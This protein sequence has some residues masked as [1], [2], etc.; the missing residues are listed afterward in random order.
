MNSGHAEFNSSS[1]PA[2]TGNK[3]ERSIKRNH[4]PEL[5][6]QVFFSEA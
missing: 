3:N 1:S 6:L 2:M 5:N 4:V